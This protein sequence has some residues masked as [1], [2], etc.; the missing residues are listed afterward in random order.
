MF[1]RFPFWASDAESVSRLRAYRDGRF[2]VRMEQTL[3]SK[4]LLSRN[5]MAH[6]TRITRFTRLF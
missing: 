4:A 5:V 6:I 1:T 2:T 3:D